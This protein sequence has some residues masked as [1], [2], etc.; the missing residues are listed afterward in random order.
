MSVADSRRTENHPGCMLKGAKSGT[1]E[2]QG[3]GRQSQCFGEAIGVV[4]ADTG[5][6]AAGSCQ[7]GRENAQ[8]LDEPPADD[9][10][11]RR[12]RS[13]RGTKRLATGVTDISPTFHEPPIA[14]AFSLHAAR[15]AR[16][17]KR[18]HGLRYKPAADADMAGGG[19]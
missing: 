4:G 6:A 12:A 19:R 1:D 9:G 3:I 11:T 2:F 10:M 8:R 7:L 17:S 16:G 13:A 14:V 5:S 15:V 18:S